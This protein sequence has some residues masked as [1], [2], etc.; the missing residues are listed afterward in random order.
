M[1]GYN[2]EKQQMSNLERM[3]AYAACVCVRDYLV[4]Q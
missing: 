4:P 3:A 1:F 2:D